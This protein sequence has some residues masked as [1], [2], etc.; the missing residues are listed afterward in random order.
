MQLLELT[1]TV[2]SLFFDNS[3]SYKVISSKQKELL[4]IIGADT[5]IKKIDNKKINNYIQ[6]LKNKNNK[7]ATINSK[8]MY[9]SKCLNYAY[10]NNLIIN[11][12]YIPVLKIQATKDK[13]ITDSELN[14]MIEY[15]NKTNQLELKYIILIGINT[16]IRI[17]NILAITG[18][19]IENNYIRIYKNK[20]NKPY[21]IPLNKTLKELLKDFNGF[22]LNYR[23]TE[24]RFKQMIKEL[25]LD[26][27]ITIHTLRHTTASK[28]VQNNIPI[29]VIQQLLNHQS[30][31]T[32]LRYT[33]I[34]NEQLEH[35]VD[36]L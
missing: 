15:C 22:S 14:K 13:Y 7:P 34:K 8:L 6:I 26:N 3:S 29:P 25:E 36:V 2:N 5:D 32:T 16:G 30:I 27:N 19:D 33:H 12:P 10:R 4:D 24:Y 11:K 35:A 31:K 28:L 20:T 23:Q 1:N 9:L 17:S 18:D 21:S